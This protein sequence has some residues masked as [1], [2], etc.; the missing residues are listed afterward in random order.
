MKVTQIF[1]LIKLI[2]NQYKTAEEI[3]RI[4]ENKIQELVA[5]AY[6]NVP[7]YKELFDSS[8]ILPSEI[9]NIKDLSL[10]PLTDKSTLQ[11]LSIEHK[12]ASNI[13]KNDCSIFMTSGTT[14]LPLTFFTTKKDITIK[15]FV[16][17]RSH[18]ARGAKPWHK[19]GVFGGDKIVNTKKS[20][21]EYLLLWRRMEISSWESNDVWVK[22]IK[23]FKPDL[24]V[25]RVTTLKLFAEIIVSRNIKGIN[26]KIIFSS[27]GIIDQKTRNFVESTF[28][29]SIVD[30]YTSFEGGCL[31]WE[32]RECGGYHI[33]S[34][35]V[36]I[37]V[38]KDGKPVSPG[39]EGE[40]VITNL[41]SKAMPFIRYRQGDMVVLSEKKPVCGRGLPL[42]EKINGRKDDYIVLKNGRKIPP[43]AIYSVF[44]PVDGIRR[45][46][47]IQND[48]KKIVVEIEPAKNFQKRSIKTLKDEMAFLTNSEIETEVK[49]VASILVD[50]AKKYRAV[51]SIFGKDF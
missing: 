20:W 32:C 26:P 51:S 34:D 18:M 42:I 40:V 3:E 29:C 44:I 33:N 17:A 35:A 24:L 28:N 25:S 14:G 7:Y 30:I 8:G 36:I 39:C 9:K 21:N 31:A 13:N 5:H 50:P 1:D 15:N 12:T 45:W 6:K 2:R 49:V 48:M 38:L 16:C 11:R 19:I 4:Q 41:Y 27:A 37:E 22:K 43:Q 46:R 10:I 23:N 47:V